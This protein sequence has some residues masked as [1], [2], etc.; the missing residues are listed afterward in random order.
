MSFALALGGLVAGYVVWRGYAPP[1]SA[2]RP[3]VPQERQF[4][5][6]ITKVGAA[7]TAQFVRW[8]PATIVVHVGDTVILQVT[9][10]DPDGA[11]GF[12]L[13]EAG[14]FE[15]QI[16]AGQTVTVRFVA[17]RP[18]IYMFS[19]ANAGC[20]ADHAEQ[21]GQLIVLGTP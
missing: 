6:V 12:A 10:T 19:C 1:A 8:I 20:A 9:N 11:H 15:R 5:V 16:P 14:I 13:P 7:E 2:T 21:K 4:H 18:G 3:V 17:A